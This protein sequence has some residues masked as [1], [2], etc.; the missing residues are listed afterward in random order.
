MKR[1]M[2]FEIGIDNYAEVFRIDI[3][4]NFRAKGV[5]RRVVQVS[6]YDGQTITTPLGEFK[7]TGDN[8]ETIEICF[9]KIK[10]HYTRAPTS[11]PA[12]IKLYDGQGDILLADG[13]V[14]ETDKGIVAKLIDNHTHKSASE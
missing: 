8:Q 13:L 1:D 9:A 6:Q 2:G 7:Y 12:R 14:K 10:D 11:L 4:T 5:D 3:M